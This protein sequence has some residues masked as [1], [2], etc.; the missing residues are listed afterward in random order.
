MPPS[1]MDGSKSSVIM[2]CQN[3]NAQKCFISASLTKLWKVN[4]TLPPTKF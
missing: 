2:N 3:I 4:V 1:S